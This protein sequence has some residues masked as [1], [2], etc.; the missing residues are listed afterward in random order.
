MR[1]SWSLIRFS[2]GSGT[3]PKRSSSSSR[4]TIRSATSRAPA[5][6]RWI[7]ILAPRRGCSR[8]ARRRPPAR[9]CAPAPG[10]LVGAPSPAEQRCDRLVEH[11]HVELEADRR[12][13][14]RLLVAEQV[15][16]AADLEVAHRDLEAGAELGVV[17]ERRQAL[18]PPPR[19]SAARRGVEQV[20]VGA[21]ARAADAAADLV[22][23]GQPEPVGALDDQRV[24]AAGCRGPTR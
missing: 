13:V 19:V 3:G 12:D 6:R 10:A 17:G 7:S 24:R 1:A 20:G 8:P 16:G 2:S 22:E 15:A 23:L 21:L 18:P 11:R 5:T 9:R 4:S 14:A